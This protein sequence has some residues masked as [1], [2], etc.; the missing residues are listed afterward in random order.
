MIKIAH[1]GNLYG[2]ERSREN[3]PSY[4]REAIEL[5]FDVE[6]D[7]W[8]ENQ[9]FFLG[10]DQTQYPIGVEFLF[11]NSR[12][13]WIHCKNYE[14]LVVMGV[15]DGGTEM[16]NYFSH[17]QDP[18]TLTS[19]GFIWA[20]PTVVPYPETIWV[21]PEMVTK[22]RYVQDELRSGNLPLGLCSDYIATYTF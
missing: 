19:R 14:A 17:D 2:A 21:C 12:N 20:Y 1:R 13:L 8:Y 15:I 4:I 7:L 3:S 5:G 18:F 10:H 6:V 11:Q 22:D 9:N 16:F